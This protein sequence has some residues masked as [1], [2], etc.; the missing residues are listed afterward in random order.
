MSLGIND[1]DAVMLALPP[2]IDPD[3]L[4]AFVL[5]AEGGSVTRAAE[6]VGRTQSAVSMQMKR[7]EDTLGRPLLARTPRGLAPTPHGVW[8]LER[9]RTLLAV[10]DEIVT[11][12]RAPPLI[13]QVRLGAPDDYALRWL[14]KILAR[15][16]ET[17]P[18]VEVEVVCV[19]SSA[20][21][22]QLLD[23]EV[24]LALLTEGNERRGLEV[25]PLWRGPLLWV[26]SA[27]H[28]VHRA[29]PLPL[30]LSH[31][32]CTWRTAACEALER[33]GRRHRVAYT[34]QTQTGCFAIVLAGLAVTVS[35]PATLPDGLVWMGEA[36]G[37]P[38]LP[39]TGLYL[40]RGAAAEDS[41]AAEALRG[42][43]IAGFREAV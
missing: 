20:L 16:A 39:E 10:N 11:G 15:F 35:T 40:A 37:L 36:D 32:G 23:G 38:P 43:I 6:R 33:A 4:R 19:N 41:P 30:A 1:I 12:F 31:A 27:T 22:K 5:V 26:G 21:A 34:S 13:G 24:D 28:P 42:R 18:A 3:L 9:A 7:L 17:H 25:E 14:P 29:E 8:L 2:G